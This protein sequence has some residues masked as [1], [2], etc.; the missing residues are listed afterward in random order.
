MSG[1][2]ITAQAILHILECQDF[3]EFYE[4]P[5]EDYCRGED[6]ALSKEEML[7]KISEI[8]NLPT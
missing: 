2:N 5:L 1:T 7:K 3:Q 8:F 6:N 4:G